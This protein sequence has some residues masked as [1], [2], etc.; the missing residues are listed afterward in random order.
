MEVSIN[1]N[2]K[3]ECQR[4]IRVKEGSKHFHVWVQLV[5]NVDNGIDSESKFE[6]TH[7]NEENQNGSD[8]SPIEIN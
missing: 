2:D 5:K 8:T 3:R 4:S 7:N 1:L 6:E